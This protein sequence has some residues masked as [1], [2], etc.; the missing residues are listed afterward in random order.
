MTEPRDVPRFRIGTQDNPVNVTVTP[1]GWFN[2]DTGER[3]ELPPDHWSAEHGLRNVEITGNF[4]SGRKA[5][6]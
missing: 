2:T 4:R 3:I 5:G 1:E 6:T